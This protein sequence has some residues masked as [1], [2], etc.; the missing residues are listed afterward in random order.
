[1]QLPWIAGSP[2]LETKLFI[3]KPRP[4]LISRQRLVDQLRQG[5][6][7][8]FTLVSA[9]AGFG[10]TTLL[11][12]S[13]APETSINQTTGW[14]SLDAKDNNPSLFWAYVIAA[15]QTIKKD[16]GETLTPLLFSPQPPPIES[17]LTLLSNEINACEEKIILVLDDYHVINAEPIHTALA[18]LLDHLPRQMHLVIASRRD[19]DLPLA[20][21]RARGESS[22]FRAEDLRFLPE[23]AA[24]FLNKSM[25]FDLSASDV[26]TLEARTEGWIA[27]LQLAALSM[28]GR[29]DVSGFIDAFAGDDRHI[30]DYLIEEVLQQLPEHNR[31]FL[32]QTSILEKLSGPLC[33]AITQQNN[34]QQVL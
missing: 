34:G 22:E 23:E 10:K 5:I 26:S 7:R 3:P 20:R 11:A 9:P 6:E 13:F 32:L 27:G 16:I 14:V 12:A 4:E 28:R 21:L 33:N 1:M 15:L 18:F 30:V 31:S 29:K 19:P 2:L 25:G 17:I 24:T 8:K